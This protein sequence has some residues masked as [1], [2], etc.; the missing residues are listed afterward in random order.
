MRY[1]A[2]GRGCSVL[3]AWTLLDGAKADHAADTGPQ[4]G[5]QVTNPFRARVPRSCWSAVV[6]VR[7]LWRDGSER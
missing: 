3:R 4:G 2:L 5:Q 1:R 7:Q 6:G